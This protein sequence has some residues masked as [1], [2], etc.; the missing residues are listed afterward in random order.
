MLSFGMGRD[1][2]GVVIVKCLIHVSNVVI[3][4][5][6]YSQPIDALN[7][8]VIQWMELKLT[9]EKRDVCK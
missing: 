4:S 7:V 6:Q 2:Y 5:N 3:S 8:I 1:G 9:I